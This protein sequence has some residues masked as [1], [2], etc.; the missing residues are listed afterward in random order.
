MGSAEIRLLRI[1]RGDGSSDMENVIEIRGLSKSF[2]NIRA[3]RDLSFEVRR[4]ELFAFLG[5]NGA[6]KST[7]MSIICGQLERDSGEAYICNINTKEHPELVARRLGV[8]FQSSGLDSALSVRDN[9][10]SRAAL[11]GIVGREFEMRLGELARML[12]FEELIGRTL[13]KLS[14][15]QK[16]KIDIARALLHRPEI[17]MLDEP[18]TGLDPNT[19]RLLWS[20][21]SDLRKNEGLTVFLTTHY[22][23]EAAEADH[24]VI[25]D[26]GRIAAEGTPLSMKNRYTGDFVT[27]YGITEEQALTIGG[28]YSAVNGGYRFR[29]ASTADAT[30]MIVKTPDL[31]TDYEI[32]KG[33]MDDVFLAVT[34]KKLV[35]GEEK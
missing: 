30:D 34:G 35:G 3:I 23:E 19:R 13:G 5:E 1:R 24:V 21:I 28:T 6:G 11:Y 15:G 26:G 8:V 25:L 22:M 14:G 16:R 32:I 18:T 4:G 7:A 33:G 2:G 20:V 31:F 12:D 17:L 10:A 27:V 9:L 29:V